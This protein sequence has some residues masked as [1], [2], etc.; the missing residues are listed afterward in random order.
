MFHIALVVSSKLCI[1]DPSVL[2]KKIQLGVPSEHRLATYSVKL[3][4]SVIRFD[5]LSSCVCLGGLSLRIWLNASED[6]LLSQIVDCDPN[7]DLVLKHS[8]PTAPVQDHNSNNTYRQVVSS[9]RCKQA[10]LGANFSLN[11][12]TSFSILKP[13]CNLQPVFASLFLL[14]TALPPTS[15]SSVEL[16]AKPSYFL[17]FTRKSSKTS[18]QPAAARRMPSSVNSA[19]LVDMSCRTASS[20]PISE[21]TSVT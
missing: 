5:L 21:F 20:T 10:T 17:S 6:S 11:L 3:L 7:E 14:Q 13:H 16:A 4:M 9:L 12:F 2:E 18:L 19:A 1:L 15:A 8:Q